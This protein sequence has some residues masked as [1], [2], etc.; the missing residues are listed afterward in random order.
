LLTINNKPIE[1]LFGIRIDSSYFIYTELNKLAHVVYLDE[2]YREF[3]ILNIYLEDEKRSE[4]VRIRGHISKI[5]GPDNS[6]MQ[7]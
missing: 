6:F 5:Y 2:K 3:K 4:E 1:D 7:D